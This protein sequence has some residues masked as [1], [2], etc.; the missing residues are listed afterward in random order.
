MSGSRLGTGSRLRG[1]Y[2][3]FAKEVWRFMKVFVQTILTPVVTALQ[4]KIVNGG[5]WDSSFVSFG[6]YDPVTA[7]FGDSDFNF[8]VY[9]P[10]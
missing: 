8:V 3:L 10:Q 1:V 9:G 5:S 2:T 4:R 6:L 7:S